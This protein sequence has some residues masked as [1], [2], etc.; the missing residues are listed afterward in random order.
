ML[1]PPQV[2]KRLG[3]THDKILV[4]IHRGEM[5]AVD[6]STTRGG[7][8]RYRVSEE[9][10]EDFLD[11]RAVTPPP[12]KQRRSRRSQGDVIEFFGA[13]GKRQSV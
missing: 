4:W 1:T 13:D 3:V 12:S 6:V 9:D 11:R 2:A 7:R 8:P 10:L 5:R